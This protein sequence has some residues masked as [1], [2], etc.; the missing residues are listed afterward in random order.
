MTALAIKPTDLYEL[1]RDHAA[2]QVALEYGHL[3]NH[4]QQ[5]QVASLIVEGAILMVETAQQV[6]TAAVQDAV[7]RGVAQ[8]FGYA[9]FE[10][11]LATLIDG[12]T[13]PSV[14]SQI[15]A[16]AG[17]TE[18]MLQLGMG[19]R[20]GEVVTADGQVSGKMRAM[21]PMIREIQRS[22]ATPEEKKE[23]IGNMLD[24]AR[25]ATYTQINNKM[26]AMGEELPIMNVVVRG[27]KATITIQTPVTR[28]P[29]LRRRLSGLVLEE[30]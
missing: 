12:H 20:L 13:S 11:W 27:S 14:V 15:K 6:L 23:Q 18:T 19:D 7:E 4:G 24:M 3:D 17:L 2:R 22:S 29:M 21:A 10:E 5:L 25:N 26:V 1:I 28:L 9:D 16:V 30:E 8:E